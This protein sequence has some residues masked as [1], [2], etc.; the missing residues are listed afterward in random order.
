MLTV[1][2]LMRTE[3]VTVRADMS[4]RKL[5]ALL[6]DEG[7]S[8]APVVDSSGEVVGVVSTKDILAAASEGVPLQDVQN[9]L[10]E[11]DWFGEALHVDTKTNVPRFDWEL[12]WPTAE[13]LDSRTVTEIMNPTKL[14][15]TPSTSV[16]D[17]AKYMTERAIHRSLVTVNDRLVGIVTTYDILLAVAEGKL[18]SAN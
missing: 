5:A 15:V 8:G 9:G 6:A 14:G 18:V 16:E 11:A 3:V 2:D 1:Q 13:G 17:L 4:V 7:I 10:V 12:V